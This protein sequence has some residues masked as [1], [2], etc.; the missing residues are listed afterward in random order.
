MKIL[1][2]IS[3]SIGVL[4]IHAYLISLQ[5][6]KEVEEIRIVMTPTAARFLSPQ[7]LEGLL[8]RPVYVDPWTDRGPMYPPPAIVKDLDLYLIAPASA[9]TLARCATGSAETLL[10]HC[11]LSH[12]GPVAF[13][14]SM[15]PEMWRHPAVLRNLERLK[16]D[17]ACIL[18]AGYGY[19]ASTGTIQRS[20]MCSYKEMWPI[21]KSLVQKSQPPEAT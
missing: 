14:P 5:V 16:E 12:T 4:G 7:T 20:S 11:Y 9:T 6:E 18:P 19:A 13:A 17:G 8:R 21:L 2:G 3:G 1:V 15:E 10:A